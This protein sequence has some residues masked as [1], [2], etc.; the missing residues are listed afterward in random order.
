MHDTKF[1]LSPANHS[2]DCGHHRRRVGPSGQDIQ[3]LDFL[4][5][6]RS[7]DFRP[8]EAIADVV[9]SA[10]SLSKLKI[11]LLGETFLL[12]IHLDR[13]HLPMLFSTHPYRNSI[14]VIFVLGGRQHRGTFPS[15]LCSGHCQRVP[16]FGRRSSRPNALVPTP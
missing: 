11:D 12:E 7:H 6:P 15:I 16:T 2:Y 14:G 4:C 9:N 10:R 8:F 1:E 3:Y 13:L 5:V